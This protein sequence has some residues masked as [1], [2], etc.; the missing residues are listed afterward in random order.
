M[1]DTSTSYLGFKLPHPIVA[2][3][4]PMVNF[5]DTVRRLEDAGA[6][7]IVM[8]SLFEEQILHHQ[9]GVD[10]HILSHMDTFAEA[11]SY[12]PKSLEFAFGPEKYLDHLSELKKAVH[13]PVFASLN[14]IHLGSWIDYARF[15]EEAGA[16]A[17][18]LNLYYLPTD[19]EV[20][21]QDLEDRSVEV[22]RS[23]R[24]E[25]ALP[26]AVKL[27]PFFTSLPHFTQRLGEAGADGLVLFNRYY[28]PNIDI[29]TLE[30]V[31][32]L[33]L[34]DSSEIHLR[35]RW[36]GL[37]YGRVDEDLALTGGVHTAQD[38]IKG[39]MAGASCVQMVSALLRNGPGHLQDLLEELI[40]WM[41]EHDY[42]SIDQMKGS[43]SYLHTPNPETIE[44]SNY[45]KILQSW[46]A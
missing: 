33:R 15:I 44:R 40:I 43:M 42:S 1:M 4:S 31:P 38:A 14:G 36:L 6:A 9:A 11:T 19:P 7:A 30:M 18:E 34:S 39:M 5:P 22:V 8:N 26:L 24:A 21:C 45:M 25:T 35:L 29:E 37:L 16:D 20:S 46:T 23:V 17:L 13:V 28:Q 27:S 3:A 2:G 10:E 32:A 12:F 41:E